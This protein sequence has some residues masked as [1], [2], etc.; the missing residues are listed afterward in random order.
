MVWTFTEADPSVFPLLSWKV[1][2]IVPPL[3]AVPCDVRKTE[4]VSDWPAV[5]DSEKGLMVETGADRH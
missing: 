5:N 1:T 4:N 2:V 3:I